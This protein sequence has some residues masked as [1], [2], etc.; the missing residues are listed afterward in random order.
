MTDKTNIIDSIIRMLGDPNITTEYL[1]S[2]SNGEW[3]I[4]HMRVGSGEPLR[5]FLDDAISDAVSEGVNEGVS[6][7]RN[8]LS[9]VD[10]LEQLDNL[11]LAYQS[12]EIKDIGYLIN[13][14]YL[15]GKRAK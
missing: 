6:A 12:G 4:D 10:T 2:C 8:D 15:I 7:I 14:A 9:F 13:K 3:W 1:I 11:Q 5:Q